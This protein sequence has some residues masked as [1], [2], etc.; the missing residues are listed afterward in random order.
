[1]VIY[2]SESRVIN[3]IIGAVRYIKN[4]LGLIRIDQGREGRRC[5]ILCL[6]IQR[7]SQGGRLLFKELAIHLRERKNLRKR[8]PH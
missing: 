6:F 7:S 1:M 2:N 8:S 5:G 3:A 4:T